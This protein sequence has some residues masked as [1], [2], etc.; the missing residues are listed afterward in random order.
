VFICVVVIERWYDSS[1]MCVCVCVCVCVCAFVD[2]INYHDDFEILVHVTC[3][4]TVSSLTEIV[5]DIFTPLSYNHDSKETCV[6]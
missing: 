2:T 3:F 5:T 6:L 4:V 1:I